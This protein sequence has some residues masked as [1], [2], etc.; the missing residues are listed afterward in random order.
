MNFANKSVILAIG[1][2][3]A[4]FTLFSSCTKQADKVKTVSH[5]FVCVKADASLKPTLLEVAENYFYVTNQKMKFDFV[6]AG[7]I[8]NSNEADSMDVT[9]FA[10]ESF[11]LPGSEAGIVDANKTVTL[12]YAIPCLI[13]PR[14]NPHLITSLSE[15]INSELKIGIA[16]S[17]SDVLGAFSLEIL[18]KNNLLDKISHRLITVGPTAMDLALKVSK[19]EIDAAI[20][21][22]SSVN[23]NPE[24]FDVVLFAPIE[25]PRVAT[26]TAARAIAPFDSA[27]ADRLMTYLNSDRC[28]EIFRKWGYLISESDVVMY[29]PAAVIGGSPEL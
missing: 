17:S 15:L 8:L 9:I 18:K 21:W 7:Q 26:I 1:A 10:N 3:C 12:A 19:S 4:A 28:K 5:N 24:S 14:L 27:N 2:I 20:A 16:D 29:A 6:P 22:T 25:I 23:W 13:V 11:V